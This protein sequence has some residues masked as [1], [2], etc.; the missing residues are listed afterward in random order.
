[1]GIRNHVHPAHE[2]LRRTPPSLSPAS[3]DG[4]VTFHN[5]NGCSQVNID[6]QMICDARRGLAANPNIYSVLAVSLGCEGCQND[7]R[8]TRRRTNKEVRTIIQEVGGSI[9]AVEE[10]TRIARELVR[11][12]SFASARVRGVDEPI[13][14]RTAA[15]SGTS[16]LQRS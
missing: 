8:S 15:A 11:E 9:R 16:N 10:G 7:L 6:Q 4:C 14:E 13:F 1:M 2:H 5:Q 12:A 3:V